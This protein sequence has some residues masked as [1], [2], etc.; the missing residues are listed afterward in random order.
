MAATGNRSSNPAHN[1]TG[2]VTKAGLDDDAFDELFASS[3]LKLV[4]LASLLLPAATGQAEDVVQEA[5]TNLYVRWPQF[6]DAA[7]AAAYVTTSVVNG[8]RSRQRFWRRH[9]SA[10]ESD[11]IGGEALS[12]EDISISRT[13]N[14]WVWEALQSLSRRQREVTVLRYWAEMTEGEIAE[15][16]GISTG[17][18]KSNSARARLALSAKLRNQDG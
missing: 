7:G 14:R 16:L 13:E 9:P 11:A 15:T 5:F 18:V 4:R 8:A 10:P 12:P 17:S 1:R 3:W 6:S 2:Q